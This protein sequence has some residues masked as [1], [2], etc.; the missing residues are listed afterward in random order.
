MYH[1]NLVKSVSFSPDG[2]YAMS[3]SVDKTARIWLWHPEDLISQTCENLPRNL[4]REEW[5]TY[6][7][8]ELYQA[9][10]ADL[11]I[12]PEETLTPNP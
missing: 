3:G 9:I 6:L 4:T 10:C 8:G 11:A 2:N 1:G 5:N 7:E 12:E